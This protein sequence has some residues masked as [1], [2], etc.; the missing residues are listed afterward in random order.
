MAEGR[1]GVGL[2]GWMRRIRIATLVVLAVL[3]LIVLFQ[4]TEPATFDV[5]FWRPQVPLALFFLGAFAA[6][7]LAGALA[8]HLL[9]RG[10]G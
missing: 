3:V 6:G 2:G 8:W 1:R 5:L 10:R 9:G 4:N 7:A